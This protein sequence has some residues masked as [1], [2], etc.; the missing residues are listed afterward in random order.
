MRPFAL[1]FIM[2]ILGKIVVKKIERLNYA[3]SNAPLAEIKSRIAGLGETR[4]F[5]SAIKKGAG[6][7]RLIAEIKKA[8]PSQGII[9]KDFDLLEIARIYRAKA[10][11]AVSVLTEEDFFCGDLNYITS[12]RQILAV[13]ILRKDFIFD[14]YQIYE[15]RANCADAILLIAA[16]L[17]SMQIRD[18]IHLSRALGLAVLLEVHN[19]RELERALSADADIIG[20]NNR[21]LKTMA[22][23]LNTTFQLRKEIPSDKIV[24]S[25]SGI[26]TNSDVRKL[27][28][29]DI[30]AMLIGTSLMAS[31]DIGKKLD[32]IR[33]DY[34]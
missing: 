19:A 5:K 22:I 13:P 29:A 31:Q 33:G 2:S 17:D 9:R 12:V 32:E 23:D 24:V 7:V 25:E 11:D 1:K 20:I 16:L 28:E 10:V 3:K 34:I 6:P 27:D 18:Y 14:E 4:D 8:S 15:S 21:D 30:D 26:K